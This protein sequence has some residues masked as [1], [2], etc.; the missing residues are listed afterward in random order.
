MN[1]QSYFFSTVGRKQMMALVGVFL[2]LFVFTHALGNMLIFVGDQTYNKYSHA[3][4][5]NPLIYIAEAGLVAFFLFHIIFGIVLT[6]R[7]F[8]ARPDKYA[9]RAAGDKATSL[10]TRSM[11]LQGIAIFLFVV[12]H[13]ITFKFGPNYVTTIDGVE[14]R[15][16]FRLVVEVFQSPAYVFGYIAVLLILCFHLSHGVYSSIQTLGVNRPQI[17]EKAKCVSCAY[18]F[19]V[20]AMFISQ[21]LYIFFFY[22]A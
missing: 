10:T 19:L 4:I 16:L 22:K 21:P 3:L 17:A 1:Q 6:I 12:F 9:V 13:L 14:M 8:K 2:A 7:N 5:S 18:G 20:A 15:D 11:M